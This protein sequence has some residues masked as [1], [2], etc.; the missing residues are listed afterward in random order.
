MMATSTVES[1][2]NQ[3]K[4]PLGTSVVPVV[5]GDYDGQFDDSI[6]TRTGPNLLSFSV[7]PALRRSFLSLHF[8]VISFV[9]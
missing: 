8:A 5:Q 2:D 7:L 6:P 3:P 1:V 4:Q 9:D